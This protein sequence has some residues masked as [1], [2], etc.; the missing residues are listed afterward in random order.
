MKD[1]IRW[2]VQLNVYNL[3]NDTD[4][5]PVAI[6]DDLVVVGRQLQ[7]GLTFKLTNTFEF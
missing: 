2:K 3:L 4:E 1:R 5:I 7:N 6:D